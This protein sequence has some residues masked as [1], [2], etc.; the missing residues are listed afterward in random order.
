MVETVE[1]LDRYRAL[2]EVLSRHAYEYARQHFAPSKF[3]AAYRKLLLAET[4]LERS[5]EA[6]GN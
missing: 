6:D 1:Q 3:C 5:S 2:L 4:P